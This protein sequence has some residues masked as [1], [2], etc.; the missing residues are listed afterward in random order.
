MSSAL[1]TDA[2]GNTCDQDYFV[3]L[4][5][6]LVKSIFVLQT[7]AVGLVGYIFSSTPDFKA[8]FF[9]VYN[10]FT[11]FSGGIGYL[12]SA[13]Y[14]LA[15]SFDYGSYVCTAGGY[16]NIATGYIETAVNFLT[17]AQDSGLF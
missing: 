12:A 7:L 14:F 1:P 3:T 11:D 6:K 15:L 13:G 16:I 2:D 9:K 5:D 10:F 8:A 17:Q 4:V